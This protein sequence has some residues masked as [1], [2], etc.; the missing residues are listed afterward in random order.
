[1]EENI[2]RIDFGQRAEERFRLVFEA[3]PNAMIMVNREGAITLVNTQTEILFGYPRSELV[4]RPIE[5]LVPGNVRPLHPN[6]RE[7]YLRNPK[8]RAMGVGRDLYGVTKTGREVPI[9]IGLNP[10]ETAEGTFV[11]A[12]IIDI[13]ERKRS[14]ERM[15]LI[16]EAAPN[17][18]VMVDKAGCI[19]L[20][21]AQTEKLFEYSRTELMGQSVDILVP[22]GFRAQH[23]DLRERFLAEPSTRAMGTG[24]D[25]YGVTKSGR[26]VPVEIGLN[27]LKTPEGTFVLASI[28]DITE[29]KLSENALRQSEDRF[30]LMVSSVQDY[31]I[32]MLDLDGHVETWNDGA[33][34]LKGYTTEEVVGKHFSLFYVPEDLARGRPNQELQIAR[35]LGRFEDEGWRVRK[36]GSRYWANVIV[37]PIPD[38]NGGI[39]GYSKV[40]RDITERMRAGEALQESELRFRAITDS[41]SEGLVIASVE[42][43]ILYWNAASRALFG[44]SSSEE[45]ALT[46]P[47]FSEVF[48]LSTLDGRIL[49]IEEWPLSRVIAGE[50]LSDC[51]VRI[52]RFN[53]DRE[54]ILSFSG[55]RV[56]G[57]SG[58]PVAFVSFADITERRR[59]E[60]VTRQINAS[61][62]RRVRERTTELTIAKDRAEAAD[63]QKSLFL[64]NMSHELRTP[65]NAVIGFTQLIHDDVVTPEMPQYKEFLGDILTSA[66]HLLKLINDVL[67]LSAVDAGK[68]AFHPESV[69]LSKLI[70]EVLGILQTS[71][72][73]KRLR[74]E[75]Y[76]DP[77]LHSV[78]LDAAR[79]KQV[80]YNY[81]SNALKFTPEGGRVTVRALSQ[82]GSTFRLEVQ[83]TGVG[84]AAAD[85]GLLFS[86]F[87]QLDQG[88]GKQHSGTGLGL[89]LTKR[90]VEAQGG[91]VGVE[92]TLGKGSVFFAVLPCHVDVGT[93]MLLPQ[94]FKGSFPSA[95]VVLVIDDN[96]EEQAVLVKALT[97]A[98]YAV[99]TAATGL[100]ALDLCRD[101]MY[102]AIT[103]DILL[104]D[105]SGI[106][107]LS[108]IRDEVVNRDTPV[109]VLTVVA[110]RG[111]V[112]DAKIHDLLP[113]PEDGSN[114]L[115]SL[116]RAGV[117]PRRSGKILLVDDDPAP[118]EQASIAI[119]K[120]GH[121]TEFARGGHDA[122]RRAEA[123][124]PLAVVV[125]LEMREM[126]GSLFIERFRQI[127]RCNRVPIVGWTGGELTAEQRSRILAG[128]QAIV[129]NQDGGSATVISELIAFL[130]SSEIQPN[131]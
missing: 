49:K 11:L 6:L 97:D 22:H 67:D 4:G 26:E 104:P 66:K 44:F 56:R 122:L 113:K 123:L 64:A 20:V 35:E 63:R 37:T 118:L 62:E 99:D 74:L 38:E 54:L 126:E 105:M 18:M 30:R 96:A 76:I 69:D 58:S 59:A 112:I 91:S 40:I 108:G 27:P 57:E 72:A 3:A 34:R 83:D 86:E 21:N 84:I 5:M 61:L 119:N 88:A 128:A 45:W 60:V 111:A 106:E 78:V 73:S 33:Q 90:L 85:I 82:E 125:N 23:A 117:P 42:G 115:A 100:Q 65:L 92:S 107:V 8:T 7:G 1:M 9:E 24:R 68:L 28:I 10:L 46:M 71:A 55:K 131:G 102:D 129:G 48:E 124:P 120:L 80:L 116:R 101:R 53:S 47:E 75:S 95:P 93:P 17:A 130:P 81:V 39:S 103:L 43:R 36:D 32:F 121:R 15:R 98:G 51:E 19:T 25:L 16:V 77:A 41:L 50:H 12:S 114:V 13:T 110:E 109:I 52:R 14:E 127:P 70:V 2:D 94:S 31:A 29:R 89:A 79:L 87:R